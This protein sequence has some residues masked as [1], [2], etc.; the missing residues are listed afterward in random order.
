MMP[1]LQRKA[2]RYVYSAKSCQGPC[3]EPADSLVLCRDLLSVSADLYSAPAASQKCEDHVVN[4]GT[5]G[6]NDGK[7]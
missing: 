1:R 3:C 2:V 5:E 4:D 7:L 6:F